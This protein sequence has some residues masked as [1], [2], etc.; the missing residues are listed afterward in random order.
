MSLFQFLRFQVLRS[1]KKPKNRNKYLYKTR[2]TSTK[3]IQHVVPSTNNKIFI[4][5][6]KIDL[7]K[8]SRQYRCAVHSALISLTTIKKYVIT[9]VSGVYHNGEGL[10]VFIIMGRKNGNRA[11][12]I[13][14]TK[15]SNHVQKICVSKAPVEKSKQKQKNE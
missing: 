1:I 7:Y 12:D 6:T 10:V 15:M 4:D 8:Y 9:G 5:F 13:P 2:S 11:L 14:E 3:P